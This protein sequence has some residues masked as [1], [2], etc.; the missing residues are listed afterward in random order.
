MMYILIVLEYKFFKYNYD[1][2]LIFF[3]LET[4]YVKHS[5]QGKKKI[6]IRW[7]TLMQ[8][9]QV[10]GKY[11]PACFSPSTAAVLTS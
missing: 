7:S 5:V 6:F 3:F 8:E 10:S 1:T 9:L 2:T 11:L 4:L